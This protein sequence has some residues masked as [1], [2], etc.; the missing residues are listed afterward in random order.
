MIFVLYLSVSLVL[1]LHMIHGHPT[2]HETEQLIT[3]D[4]TEQ[5]NPVGEKEHAAK[6]F[7]QKF[8]TKLANRKVDFGRAVQRVFRKQIILVNGDYQGQL[9]EYMKPKQSEDQRL[10]ETL[11]TNITKIN[12]I[13]EIGS[14]NN[15]PDPAETL[16]TLQSEKRELLTAYQ[17]R[18]AELLKE[19][20]DYEMTIKK[21]ME[22]RTEALSTMYDTFIEK[23]DLKFNETILA[24][25]KNVEMASAKYITKD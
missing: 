5:Q 22:K 13:I 25:N 11:H 1:Q 7:V 9:T 15:D 4:D 18:S 23:V 3:H 17:E 20:E 24:F 8:K 16:K 14:R 6:Q 12:H 19:I 2:Y 21:E 10:R